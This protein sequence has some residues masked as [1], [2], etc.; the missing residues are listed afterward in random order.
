MSGPK[1]TILT[2]GFDQSFKFLATHFGHF[3]DPTTLVFFYDVISKM[4]AIERV[5]N[6]RPF[7]KLHHRKKS[8]NGGILKMTKMC[9]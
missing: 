5:D 6:E 2:V 3:R 8:R 9:C 4:T 7:L 1:K